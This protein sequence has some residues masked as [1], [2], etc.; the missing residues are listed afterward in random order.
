MIYS[1]LPV[2]AGLLARR[3]WTPTA[4]AR[5]ALVLV[6]CVALAFQAL[7]RV[8]GAAGPLFGAPLTAL[9]LLA[10]AC[11]PSL[12]AAVVAL[13]LTRLLPAAGISRIEAALA[14]GYRNGTVAWV[15]AAPILPPEGHLFMALTALPVFATPAIV[16]QFV[17]HARI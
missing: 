9:R 3:A 6:A 12:A 14:G 7:A 11:L 1:L 17:R 5:A 15:I 8:D 16:R 10:L 2:V 4:G 13:V